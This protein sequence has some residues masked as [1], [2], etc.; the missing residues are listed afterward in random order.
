MSEKRFK[1][2]WFFTF[3]KEKNYFPHVITKNR[4]FKRK[5]DIKGDIKGDDRSIFLYSSITSM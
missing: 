3:F 1:K 4:P 2:K 5:V